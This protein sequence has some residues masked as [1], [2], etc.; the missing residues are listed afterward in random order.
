M[1]LPQEVTKIANVFEKIDNAPKNGTSQKKN[2]NNNE[3]SSTK[4][5]VE[6]YEELEVT[7]IVTKASV[8]QR[9][10]KFNQRDNVRVQKFNKYNF[11]TTANSNK[12]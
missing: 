12:K 10:R 11:A 8:G 2:N 1:R 6:V 4:Q 9:G 5:K 7:A 3:V